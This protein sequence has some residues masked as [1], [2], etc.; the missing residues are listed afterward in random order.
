MPSQP[1][2]LPPF[3]SIA[4]CSDKRME[5]P[6]HVAAASLLEH[7][8][9]GVVAHLY[10]LL[11]GFSPADI[12]CLRHT[13]D[14]TGGTYQL[15]IV[16]P[17]TAACF[18]SLPTLHGDIVTYYRLLL[19]A[20]VPVDR[21]L[22][23]DVDLKINIDVCPLFTL[24]MQG[25]P[26]GFVVDGV[27]ANVLDKPL[28]FKVG[29]TANSPA[30]N[31]GVMLFDCNRWRA[32]N[33]TRRAL[34]FARQHAPL[35]V[36]H[37]QSVLN[38]LFADTCCH[39][40]PRYNTKL[41]NHYQPRQHAPEGIFHYVGS[42]KPWD[43]GGSFLMDYAADWHQAARR[44]ALPWPRRTSWINLHAWRRLPHLFGGYKRCIAYRLRQRF[45]RTA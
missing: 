8:H 30:F 45:S 2:V 31:A 12:A 41:Y 25:A 21:L 22:Y 34:D 15:N 1:V 14:R 24:D 42:P 23:L 28:Q 7:L 3:I 10:L 38:A 5:A 27:V 20:L 40:D 35:L 11:E 17:P 29:R 32:D 44:T 9:P 13:L 37:D 26:A 19:P 36:S 16:P 33:W 4:F 39:L 18:A 6:L 43:L